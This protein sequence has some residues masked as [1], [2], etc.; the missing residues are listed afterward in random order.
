MQGSIERDVE[1]YGGGEYL[2]EAAIRWLEA[3]IRYSE[4][5]LLILPVPTESGCKIGRH[6]P[7]YL[8]PQELPFYYFLH[9]IIVMLSDFIVFF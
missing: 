6:Y 2:R 3:E 1:S 9:C 7:I 4:P 5:N 8:Y